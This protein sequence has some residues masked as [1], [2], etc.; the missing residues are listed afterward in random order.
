MKILILTSLI[1]MAVSSAQAA[2]ETGKT[3]YSKAKKQENFDAQV[4][5]G[6]IYRPDLS[7]VTGDT[8]L[9]GNGALKLRDDFIDHAQLEREEER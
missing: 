5:E 6:Q 7:V 8:S 3:K 2:P 4:V 1:V 9:G